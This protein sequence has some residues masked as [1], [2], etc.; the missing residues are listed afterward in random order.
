M[1][2]GFTTHKMRV[3]KCPVAILK[4]KIWDYSKSKRNI[5]S[6]STWISARSITNRLGL[7]GYIFWFHPIIQWVYNSQNESLKLPGCK[8]EEKF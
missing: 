2:Q 5:T 3:G 8:F 4:K 7:L 1:I 6:R